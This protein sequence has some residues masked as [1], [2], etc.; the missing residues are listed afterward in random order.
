MKVL[1]QAVGA[2]AIQGTLGTRFEPTGV[3]VVDGALWTSSDVVV[4]TVVV[5][6]AADGRGD[7]R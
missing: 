2:Q 3:R 1:R 4:S 5:A 7:G 6:A